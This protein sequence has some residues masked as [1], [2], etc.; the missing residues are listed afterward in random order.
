[1]EEQ[2]NEDI[3]VSLNCFV[4]NEERGLGLNK[5]VF[6][7]WQF[8]LTDKSVIVICATMCYCFHE[9]C[10]ALKARNLTVK[11]ADLSVQLS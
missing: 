3:D 7:N 2:L 10:G 9:V 5:F 6:Q 8:E 4:I 1:M 11:N